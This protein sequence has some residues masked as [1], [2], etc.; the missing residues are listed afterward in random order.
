MVH[1]RDDGFFWFLAAEQ[2]SDAYLSLQIIF[3]SFGP[4]AQTRMFFFINLGVGKRGRM[5]VGRLEV[6]LVGCPRRT[7][8]PS[9]FGNKKGTSF[10]R[11]ALESRML[12]VQKGSLIMDLANHNMM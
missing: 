6:P 3:V 11:R 2:G 12:A 1:D 10:G 4:E 8:V 5:V 7:S 9:T